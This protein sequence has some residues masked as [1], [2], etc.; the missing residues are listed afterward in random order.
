MLKMLNA[1]YLHRKYFEMF[2][3]ED[4]L[5]K[6]NVCGCL[7]WVRGAIC[8]MFDFEVIQMY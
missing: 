2:K 5:W 4:Y 1:F 3:D 8:S 6:R 7:I